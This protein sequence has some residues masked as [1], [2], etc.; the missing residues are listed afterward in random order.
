MF[1]IQ[2]FSVNVCVLQKYFFFLSFNPTNTVTLKSAKVH[3][4]TCSMLGHVKLCESQ[5]DSSKVLLEK[6]KHEKI[7]TQH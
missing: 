5:T 6:K 2:K 1:G 7:V 3:I 4:G